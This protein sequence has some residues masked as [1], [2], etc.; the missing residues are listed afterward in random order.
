MTAASSWLDHV[1]LIVRDLREA[2]DVINWARFR[3]FRK[4]PQEA[5]T[6]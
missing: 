5:R 2:H 4:L 1:G 6:T 3:N